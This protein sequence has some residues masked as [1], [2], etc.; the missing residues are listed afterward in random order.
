M[1]DHETPSIRRDRTRQQEQMATQTRSRKRRLPA[2]P[3]TTFYDLPPHPKSTRREAPE[4]DAL[5]FG[6]AAPFAVGVR[7]IRMKASGSQR[8][9]T[10]NGHQ[11]S[12]IAYIY[13]III[14]PMLPLRT[15][16][17][18]E[19]APK[20]SSASH[21]DHHCHL[22]GHFRYLSREKIFT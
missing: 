13:V 18:G 9:P 12:S 17:Q 2:R 19:T 7:D 8:P 10:V 14:S 15:L 1:I 3:S 11:R 4:K 16:R 5:L 22:D 6:G 20:H 21:L